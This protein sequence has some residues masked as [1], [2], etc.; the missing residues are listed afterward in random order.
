[1]M[2]SAEELTNTNHMIVATLIAIAE[3]HSVP[4]STS[5]VQPAD[6]HSISGP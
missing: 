6:S 2:I 1:M 4:E 3:A 5:V